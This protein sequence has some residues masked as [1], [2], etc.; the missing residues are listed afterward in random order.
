MNKYIWVCESAF[1]HE[2][3]VRKHSIFEGLKA[4]MF[5]IIKN[6]CF[7]STNTLQ[8]TVSHELSLH[9]NTVSS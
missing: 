6:I 4:T 7:W 3:L 9:P 2:V 8:N 5:A 1:R